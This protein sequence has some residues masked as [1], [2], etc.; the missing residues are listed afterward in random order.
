[1]ATIATKTLPS[2]ATI[3]VIGLGVYQ[4]EPGA[5]TYN[6]VLSALKLGYRHIDTAQFYR[7][8]ADV[9]KAIVDSGVPRDQI[10]VTS[11][12]VSPV[13]N[14][15]EVLNAVKESVE[16]V[17]GGYIDLFLLHAPFDPATR[18]DAWRALEDAQSAGLLRNIGVSNFGEEHLKK[19]AETWRVK[20]AVNQVE[21]HP[22]LTRTDTVKFCESQG[23]YLEAYSPLA[24]AKKIDNAVLVA[25][26]DEVKATPA[27]V[28]VA[29]SLAK[30]FIT[31]PKSVKESRQQ[32]NLD[33][34]K[35]TLSAEQVQRLD[36]LDEYFFVGWDPI[37]QHA[38]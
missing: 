1:M 10:F 34:Y 33:S 14:Y 17:G 25:I 27:Q 18:A 28:L 16:R 9:G 11:K 13:W 4:S 20:P 31:L 8:E 7:N 38:V 3:P 15:D 21:L 22:W 26:A 2:G 23:I 19:L 32:E 30:G 5:E 36:A 35:V 37:K 12:I 24:Q 6:A 29:W